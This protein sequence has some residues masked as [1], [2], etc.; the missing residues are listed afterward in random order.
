LLYR[1]L[2]LSD[3]ASLTKL[4]A[5]TSRG[6]GTTVHRNVSEITT[7][8]TI[9]FQFSAEH[10]D[11]YPGLIDDTICLIETAD[12]LTAFICRYRFVSILPERIL[13]ALID[14][15]SSSIKTLWGFWLQT[16]V[17]AKGEM[18]KRLTSFPQMEKL[19]IGLL[20]SRDFIAVFHLHH[21]LNHHPHN[22]LPIEQPQSTCVLFN[23]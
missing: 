15:R 5:S 23:R 11:D 9:G 22:K 4:V 21:R 14:R 2:Y 10:C 20:K 7:G 17:P 1:Q 8:I 3:P 6:R 12:R 19:M 18:L 16:K 13:K